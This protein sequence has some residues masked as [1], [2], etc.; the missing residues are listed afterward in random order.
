MLGEL[1]WGQAYIFRYFSA[2]ECFSAA[3]HRSCMPQHAA[4]I[5]VPILLVLCAFSAP[6]AGRPLARFFPSIEHI[7]DP[8]PF[9]SVQVRLLKSALP[10]TIVVSGSKGIDVYSANEPN[11]LVLLA[12]NEK[13]TI[14]T[15]GLRLFFT[16]GEA[17][18]I[19]AIR[20]NLRQP[21][22]GH[23]QI[24]LAEAQSK[25]TREHRY[26]GLL[27]LEVDPTRASTVKIVNQVAIEDYVTSVLASEFGFEELEASKAMAI[28]VRTLSWRSLLQNGP[29]YELPDHD[30][31]QVYHGIGP[32][33]R[34]AR[35]ATRL[36]EGQVLT[37]GGDLI[38]AVY[39]SSSGGIT[40][41]HEEVWDAQL[42]LPYL[43]GKNDPT[44]A[45]SPY[46]DWT[47]E[48]PK[49]ELL[50]ALSEDNEMKVTGIRVGTIGKDGR[51]QEIELLQSGGESR[52][53][54]SNAFRMTANRRFG[55]DKLRSTLFGM[56]S[57][58]NAY[59]FKGKG[60]GH[61][62]GLS[63]YGALEL[64]RQGM[65]Y[66]QI[67]AHYFEGATVN[68][69]QNPEALVAAGDG[70]VVPTSESLGL[71]MDTSAP[72]SASGAPTRSEPRPTPE[73]GPTSIAF[74]GQA[75]APSRSRSAKRPAR[76]KIGW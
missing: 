63:Q 55:K 21:E 24:E 62:V 57:T 8:S 45:I 52:A 40:A 71:S 30:I 13:M 47:I 7:A 70:A 34:T 60:Y 61:G 76:R 9:D 15:S 1:F 51:V 53:I 26:E 49:R 42:I 38:E 48:L 5:W 50:E 73:V 4:R 28:C 44:D 43:R 58:D 35:E 6:V 46:S 65:L 41:N 64:S 66:N 25:P 36:T 19:Y 18:G 14:T 31:W 2:P 29:D 56:S 37:Y 10:R 54:R 67:L 27:K 17:R 23:I 12:A 68:V 39:H 69:P 16:S 72:R 32:I 74:E 75:P 59:I 33:T 20:M 3:I 22:G 11:P